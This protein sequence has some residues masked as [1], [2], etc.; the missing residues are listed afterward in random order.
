ME[1]LCGVQRPVGI[2]EKFAC[3]Q[4]EIGLAAAEDVVGLSRAGNH[5]DG[6]GGEAGFAADA[7]GE[8]GLI[9]GADGNLRG[10]DVAAAGDIEEMDS[11]CFEQACEIDGLVEIP[12]AGSPVC[13][14]DADQERQ[15]CGP[16]GADGV[17]DFEEE[18]GA[19]FEAAAV[20]ICA[21]IADG[22]EEFVQQVT[23]SGVNFDDVEAGAVGADGGVAEGG[24]DAGDAFGIEGVG[25]GEV[26]GKGDGRGR[27]DV[28]P[29]AFGGRDD[30]V[31]FPGRTHAGFAAGVGELNA[32]AG[33][34][35]MEEVD[36]AGERGDVLV[37]PEA[38]VK[39]RDAAFGRDGSGLS[40]DESG[41]ADGAAA[42]VD[43]MPVGGESVFAGV[44]AHGRDGDAVGKGDAGKGKRRK[45][46]RGNVHDGF[47]VRQL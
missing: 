16:D 20:L 41:A 2:A 1:F 34:V 14:G 28:G 30:A 15:V 26:V 27:D 5:A 44:L 39:R 21:V 9:A 29:S 22:R 46:M 18:A 6:A 3:K 17:N 11:M 47:D 25:C 40:E 4:D 42:E 33:A 8:G 32:G 19:V 36:D 35:S 43:E 13:G 31:M 12:A 37:F 10:G 24:F 38:E 23:V 45:E 7:L